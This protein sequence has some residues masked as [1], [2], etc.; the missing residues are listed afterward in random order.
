MPKGVYRD[1]T[2]QKFGSWKAL[3][4]IDGPR[5]GK[6]YWVCICECG[7]TGAVP[8]HSLTSGRSRGCRPCGAHRAHRLRKGSKGESGG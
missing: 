6:V 2:D 5:K 4:R 1:L 8:G 3:Y 7:V